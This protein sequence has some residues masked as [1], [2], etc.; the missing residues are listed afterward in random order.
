GAPHPPKLDTSKLQ[1]AARVLPR[2]RECSVAHPPIEPV[3]EQAC[4]IR[5]RLSIGGLLL[6]DELWDEAHF[7]GAGCGR[8]QAVI[9]A[10]ADLQR[11]RYESAGNEYIANPPRRHRDAESGEHHRRDSQVLVPIWTK[12]NANRSREGNE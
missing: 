10:C 5:V 9:Q 1:Y 11:S 2:P 8:A 3:L 7:A 12:R 6:G 4:H